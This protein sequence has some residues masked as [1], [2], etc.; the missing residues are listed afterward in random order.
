MAYNLALEEK[1]ERHGT[2]DL[3]KKKMFGGIGYMLAGNMCFGI[4]KEDLVLRATET[5]GTALLKNLNIRPFDIT[6]KPMKGWLL[7]NSEVWDKDVE[8]EKLLK[9]GR[10]FAGSL[11]PK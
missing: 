1:I 10:A 6:G 4:H 8:L 3:V 7:V 2:S 9:I 11:P 5:D